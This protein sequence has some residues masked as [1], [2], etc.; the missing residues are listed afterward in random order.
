MESRG[1][2]ADS[3]GRALASPYTPICR[4]GDLEQPCPNSRVEAGYGRIYISDFLNVQVFDS[5]GTHRNSIDID[6]GAAFGLAFDDQNHL[7]VV[8]NQNVVT[9]YKVQPPAGK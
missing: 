5:S 8:T 4:R 7:F 6:Q 1:P 3:G 2:I 9:K